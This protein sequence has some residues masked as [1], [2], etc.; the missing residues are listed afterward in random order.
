MA[1]YLMHCVLD[2]NWGLEKEFG[3]SEFVS[4]LILKGFAGEFLEFDWI[5]GHK[6]HS[7]GRKDFKGGVKIGKRD[8]A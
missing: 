1:I 7:K 6:L 8:F 3:S 5:G 2:G 4:S